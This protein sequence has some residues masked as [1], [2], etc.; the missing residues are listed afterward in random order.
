MEQI[1]NN[2]DA[3]VTHNQNIDDLKK[4][5]ADLRKE[6]AKYRI[7]AKNANA[8][9]I[10]A[11][12]QLK[13]IQL[14]LDTTK[15]ECLILKRQALLDKAGCLKSELVAPAIPDDCEDIQSWIDNYK[16]QNQILFKKEP[17]HGG[18]FKPSSINNL[19]PSAM[20]NSFIR[21]AAGR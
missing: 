17:N 6:A 5:I 9:T 7:N 4:E 18:G 13:S 19:S 14:E 3:V 15:K 11:Q 20:M 2:D 21:N 8:E 1:F 10:S 16:A 12:E